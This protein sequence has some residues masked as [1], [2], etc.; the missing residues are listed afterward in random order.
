MSTKKKSNKINFLIVVLGLFTVIGLI[1]GGTYFLNE[2]GLIS[3]GNMPEGGG[4]RPDGPPADFEEGGEMP[5]RPEGGEAGGMGF[6][7]QALSGFFKAILQIS[8]VVFVIAGGQSLF[9]WLQRRRRR[10]PAHSG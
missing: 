3:A 4:E 1:A 5:A 9:S 10:V 7:S 6:N 8:I 2:Q